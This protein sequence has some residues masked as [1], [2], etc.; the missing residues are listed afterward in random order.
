M[1]PQA[2]TRYFRR[3]AVGAGSCALVGRISCPVDRFRGGEEM[4]QFARIALALCV[5]LA[6][7][8]I[9]GAQSWTNL[10]NQLTIL[11]NQ[12]PYVVPMGPMIQL[13]D[14]RILVHE[15]QDNFPQ[16]WWILTPDATGNYVNGTWSDGG[17]LD[18]S[19]GP[20]YFGSQLLLNGHELVIE[21]G[22]YNNNCSGGSGRP[23]A[24]SELSCL[25]AV[26]PGCLTALPRLRVGAPSAMP[27]ASSS[28]MDSYMQSSCCSS[29]ERDLQWA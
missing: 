25:G 27:R 4:K 16:Q 28:R 8:G 24:R 18:P 1:R 12:M 14:G 9:A 7:A 5:L 3:T 10:N 17:L 2:S 6:L 22:E 15:E 20:F 21:G 23:W 19:Y 13:R 11:V 29:R 26:F